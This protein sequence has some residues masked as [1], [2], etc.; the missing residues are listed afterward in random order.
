MRPLGGYTF[1]FALFLNVMPFS[2]I[3]VF[4]QRC[5]I[6]SEALKAT[7]YLSVAFQL[8]IYKLPGF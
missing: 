5:L 4:G 1:I 3:S 7:S 6:L 8:Q 2:W